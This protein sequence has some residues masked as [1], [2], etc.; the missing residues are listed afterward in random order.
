M[1]ISPILEAVRVS[2]SSE[3]D[4]KSMVSLQEAWDCCEHEKFSDIESQLSILQVSHLSKSHFSLIFHIKF[5]FFKGLVLARN[6]YMIVNL[7]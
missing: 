3:M 5:R 4:L 2:I 7:N 1:I 6:C